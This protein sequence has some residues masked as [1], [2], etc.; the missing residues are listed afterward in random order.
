MVQILKGLLH[1]VN[2]IIH[3]SEDTLVEIV[4]CDL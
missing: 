4:I 3:M 1:K 2:G